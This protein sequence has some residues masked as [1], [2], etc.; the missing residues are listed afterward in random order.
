[1]SGE[2]IAHTHTHTRLRPVVKRART[3]NINV[4]E[5][6]RR[7]YDFFLFLRNTILY[8]SKR[9]II[10]TYKSYRDTRVTRRASDMTFRKVIYRT[11]GIERY[12]QRG[13]AKTVAG[14]FLTGEYRSGGTRRASR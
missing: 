12:S 7:G 3:R 4:Y 9:I 14:D 13:V 6:T 10:R 2:S 11:D 8:L 1:V 5:S